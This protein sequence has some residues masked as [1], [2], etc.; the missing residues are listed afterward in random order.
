MRSCAWSTASCAPSA[1]S[2]RSTLAPCTSFTTS[3]ARA[4]FLCSPPLLVRWRALTLVPAYLPRARSLIAFNRGGAIYLN[5]RFY[6][7][8]H[9]QLVVQGKMTEPLISTYHSVAHEIAH[10]C[11]PLSRSSSLSSS[12]PRSSAQ[13]SDR[14]LTLTSSTA[15]SSRTTPSSTST[16]RSSA[17]STLSRWPGC[18]SRQEEGSRRRHFCSARPLQMTSLESSAER[19]RARERGARRSGEEEERSERRARRRRRRRVLLP[20]V[21]ERPASALSYS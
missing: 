13:P 14:Q 8:W 4:S 16:S 17:R 20:R 7:A 21:L 9:D 6:A 12:A 3:R 15:S 11:V 5:Y 1:R 18:C 2:L 10:K 19:E